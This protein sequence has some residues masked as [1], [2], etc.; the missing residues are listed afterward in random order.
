MKRHFLTLSAVVCSLVVLSACASGNKLVLPGEI[1]RPPVAGPPPAGPPAVAV[2]DFSYTPEGREP[3]VIGRDHDQVRDVVWNG[4]PGRTMADL[5]AGAFAD[6]GI[7]A[8]RVK[9]G[10]PA[11]DNA[12]I[13]VSGTVRRFEVDIRRRKMFNVETEA[14]V[15]MSLTASGRGL[16]A[17]L[18]TS[19]TITQTSKDVYPL[20]EYYRM[21]L[22]LAANAAADEGVRR[23]KEGGVAGTS[24]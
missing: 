2:A 1:T 24:R 9:A 22:S 7:P 13:L 6:R 3:G 5:V 10:A 12:S 20:P 8:S 23:L 17:P 21:M 19:V 18:E 11:S 14:T 4:E 16:P 15:V